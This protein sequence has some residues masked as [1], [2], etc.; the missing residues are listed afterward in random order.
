KGSHRRRLLRML[1]RRFAT[2][3]P[4][5][6]AA[7]RRLRA[8]SCLGVFVALV[9][10]SVPAGAQSNQLVDS[11]AVMH[12]TV[13]D[14]TGAPPRPDMTVLIVGYQIVDIGKSGAVSIPRQA[15]TIDARGAFLIPGLWDMHAHPDDPELW[16][17]NP[18]PKEKEKLLTLLI[19]NGVTGIRD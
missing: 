3:A 12:V 11:L 10:A 1:L 4:R 13:I 15:R 14:G 8:A 19:A 18:P 2:K 17:V 7:L 9:L 16:P 6:E 5:H